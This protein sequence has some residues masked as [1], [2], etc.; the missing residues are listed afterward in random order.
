MVVGVGTCESEREG[1][2][3][4]GRIVTDRGARGGLWG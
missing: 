2:L 3:E 1:H 4:E